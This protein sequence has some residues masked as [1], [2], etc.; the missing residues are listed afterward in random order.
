MSPSCPGPRARAN[1]SKSASNLPHPP[2]SHEPDHRRFVLDAQHEA[3][4]RT[5][6]QKA[7]LVPCG[8]EGVR[9]SLLAPAA[10][11]ECVCV[12]GS[13]LFTPPPLGRLRRSTQLT[14]RNSLYPRPRPLD[15]GS[16]GHRL[17]TRDAAPYVG[18][19][20]W[21]R[22]CSGK[23]GCSVAHRQPH[24]PSTTTG[25]QAGSTE[26]QNP[27]GACMGHLV[28]NGILPLQQ[29]HYPADG[30]APHRHTA[31]RARTAMGRPWLVS[32]W[33]MWH[34]CRSLASCINEIHHP[35]DR[36]KMSGVEANRR[37]ARPESCRTA[38]GNQ[39]ES[40]RHCGKPIHV[41]HIGLLP[42][43]CHPP[44]TAT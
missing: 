37:P 22:L 10:A 38:T 3:P 18:C 6:C 32:L 17:G 23:A 31:C 24:V 35:V 28:E 42:G 13:A 34:P 1:L 5:T 29:I 36:A 15:E 20:M 8:H 26:G 43:C 2:A 39:R 27:H 41:F 12:P 4:Y 33:S 16:V 21:V 14:A 40:L 9:V 44:A 11:S 30:R 7:R 19:G 25:I